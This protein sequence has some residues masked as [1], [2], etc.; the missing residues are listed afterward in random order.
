MQYSGLKNSYNRIYFF[1]FVVAL[2]IKHGVT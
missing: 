1:S 2:W